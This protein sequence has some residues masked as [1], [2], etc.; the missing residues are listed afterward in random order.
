M[1]KEEIK[2]LKECNNAKTK[3]L[4]LKYFN[5]ISEEQYQRAN[6]LYVQKFALKVFK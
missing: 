4:Y 3:L 5:I 2:I 6:S 1:K